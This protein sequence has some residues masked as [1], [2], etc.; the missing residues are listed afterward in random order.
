MMSSYKACV[1]SLGATLEVAVEKNS[2]SNV[3]I[4]IDL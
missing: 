4:L 3:T 2:N 1:V